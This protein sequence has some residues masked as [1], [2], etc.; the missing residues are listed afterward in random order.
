MDKIHGNVV[1][2]SPHVKHDNK[3]HEPI[4]VGLTRD[5]L[6]A[7]IK[8]SSNN[9]TIPG[10]F[11]PKLHSPT[12]V[13][14]IN[15]NE[16]NIKDEASMKDGGVGVENK[17]QDERAH[18]VKQ[19]DECDN[20][21]TVPQIIASRLSKLRQTN[22]A[23]KREQMK[24]MKLPELPE[25]GEVSNQSR[26]SVN[27]PDDFDK[28][29][30]PPPP[31]DDDVSPSIPD[32]FL[33]KLGLKV[34][35]DNT[36]PTSADNLPEKEV[37]NK[38]NALSLAFRTDR[39]TLDKRLEIQERARDIS[40]QNVDQELHGL[41]EAVETLNR[42]CSDTQ[43]REVITKI[44]NHIDVLEQCAARVSSR[45]E[46]LGAVQQ[47]RR[48]CRAMEVMIVHVDNQKRLYEKD[49]SELEEAR[50]VLQ[51]RP[52][53]SLYGDAPTE[54][55]RSMSVCVA[56]G[57][58][59]QRNNKITTLHVIAS[60][61]LPDK[62]R[63]RSDV[64]LPRVLGGRG[65]PPFLHSSSL[66]HSIFEKKIGQFKDSSSL[67]SSNSFD[68]EEDPKQ[69]FQS[70][71]ASTSMK[72]AVTTVIRRASL[73]RQ[74]SLSPSRS[75][76][77]ENLTEIKKEKEESRSLRPNLIAAKKSS[78]EEEAYQKGFEDGVK[79]KISK[80][81]GK[82]REQQNGVSSTLE[83]IMDKVEQE[84]QDEE[85]DIKNSDKLRQALMTKIKMFI[86]NKKEFGQRIR[87]TLAGLIFA[88]AVLTAIVT[89]MPSNVSAVE[90]VTDVRHHAVPP[91]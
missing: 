27:L 83:K 87:Y 71:V 70:A 46:V 33:E 86:P 78:Q 56:N 60:S 43:I 85:E 17:E 40:E 53:G 34:G 37:E 2:K 19:E 14:N 81:L 67:T 49:H 1:R 38:F 39:L 55:R 91:L 89:L 26:Y 20:I 69:R 68:D 15:N 59:R 48:M 11:P 30:T 80:D 7:H 35:K 72:N 61:K 36:D 66:D 8:N 31:S 58:P 24:T 64:A 84:K 5:D 57:G 45:A 9:H 88:F 52:F 18:I 74:S 25:Q 6:L 51:D 41:R 62:L 73:E 65:C 29:L 44:R 63:R 21:S 82:L 76:S 13:K 32:S 23:K 4:P 50:K 42:L 54:T 16:E 28:S 77:R 75:S 3:Q 10:S 47:E 79:M 22:L 90:I 12:S